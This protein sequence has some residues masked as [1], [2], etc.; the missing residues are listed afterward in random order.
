[1]KCN[2]NWS[3]DVNCN[4]G[5]KQRCPL[6]P[7]LFGIFTNKIEKCLEGEGCT[8][9]KMVE[10]IVY[11]PLYFDDIVLPAKFIDDLNKKLNV[12]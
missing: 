9:I 7:T 12:L 1:M 3:I 8:S 2:T 11:L 6:S 4:I 5:V 10:L